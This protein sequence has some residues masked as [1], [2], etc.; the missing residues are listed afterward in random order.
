MHDALNAL[1]VD[2][3][4]PS[5]KDL[6]VVLLPL[7][8]DNFAN[9]LRKRALEPR[10]FIKQIHTEVNHMNGCITLFFGNIFL[11]KCLTFVR[12]YRSRATNRTRELVRALYCSGKDPAVAERAAI[13]ES[14]L[15]TS[16]V[17][18]ELAAATFHRDKPSA[19][20]LDFVV[21]TV[22]LHWPFSFTIL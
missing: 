14:K 1:L 12:N 2:N 7:A 13:V 9:E 17:I 20:D 22:C 18:T 21:I 5:K 19:S 6:K 10:D 16:K 8:K 11:F 4:T 15:K 3:K